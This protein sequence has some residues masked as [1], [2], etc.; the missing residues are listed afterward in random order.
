MI[1]YIYPLLWGLSVAIT[2]GSLEDGPVTALRVATQEAPGGSRL[3][4][5][6]VE[7]DVTAEEERQVELVLQERTH[8]QRLRV[9]DDED[10]FAS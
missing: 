9:V 3:G 10:V 4:R 1:K 8:S 2:V 5:V 6:L 7:A